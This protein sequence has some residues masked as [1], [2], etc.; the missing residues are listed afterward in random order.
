MG[1][2]VDTDMKQFETEQA[3]LEKK[4]IIFE[5]GNS[6]ISLGQQASLLDISQTIQALDQVATFLG[7]FPIIHI[8]GF[9]SPDG[10]KGF[11]DHL[12]TMRGTAVLEALN[13]KQYQVSRLMLGNMES[14]ALSALF[15]AEEALSPGRYVKF[16]VAWES[17]RAAKGR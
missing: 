11:N 9:T 1:Q 12:K 15:S 5:V 13:Q 6:N 14:D 2:L 8:Q 4:S 10:G 16:R 3:R 17:E 7:I